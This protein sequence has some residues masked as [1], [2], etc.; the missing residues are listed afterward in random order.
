MRYLVADW[1][2]N[3][4]HLSGARDVSSPGVPFKCLVGF[5]IDFGVLLIQLLFV[6]VLPTVANGVE[7][8]DPHLLSSLRCPHTAVPSSCPPF[9]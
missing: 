1:A 4:N 9:E 8:I 7:T 2:L 5:Y 6:E 3:T